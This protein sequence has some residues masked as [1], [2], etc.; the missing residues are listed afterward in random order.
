VKQQQLW[1][2]QDGPEAADRQ[3]SISPATKR[4]RRG[5]DRAAT[6]ILTGEA[7]ETLR[8][9]IPNVT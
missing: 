7:H 3:K 4:A 8:R 5:R 1:K 6:G 2:P 9:F